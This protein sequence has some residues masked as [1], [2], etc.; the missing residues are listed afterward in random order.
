MLGYVQKAEMHSFP[1]MPIM[2]GIDL[3]E[4]G[5][6]EDFLQKSAEKNSV[7]EVH[8]SGSPDFAGA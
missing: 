7:F 3:F 5:Q 4:V 1:N 2:G 6:K 8:K